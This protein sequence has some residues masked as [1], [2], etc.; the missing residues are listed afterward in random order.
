ML[1]LIFNR[2][3]REMALPCGLYQ[4]GGGVPLSQAAAF[5]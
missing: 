4:A 5:H 1:N 2:A 3:R